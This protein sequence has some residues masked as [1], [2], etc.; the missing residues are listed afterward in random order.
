[1]AAT[2]ATGCRAA[3]GAD[4]INGGAGSDTVSY[5]D[6]AYGITAEMYFD[7]EASHGYTEGKITAG[8][9][10]IDTLVSIENVEGSAF[11][12]YLIGDERANTFWGLGGDDTIVGDRE[13][14]PQGSADTMYGGAGNDS[15]LI[16]ASDTAYGGQGHD[17]A[18]FVGGPIY[19]NY[20]TNTF[21]VGGQSIWIAEFEAYMGTGGSDT[22]FGAAYGET[23]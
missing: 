4:Y 16:G 19:I 8:E 7:G 6:A 1:M 3:S 13:G 17:T 9:W 20:S 21:T 23:I 14:G 22:V 10:G 15:I 11:G 12:D 2:R 5:A 18:S